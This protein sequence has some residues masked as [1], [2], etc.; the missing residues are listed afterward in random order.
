VAAF[1]QPRQAWE[2]LGSN[3]ALSA[4]KIPDRVLDELTANLLQELE[5]RGLTSLRGPASVAACREIVLSEEPV[6][7][8]NARQYWAEVGRCVSVDLILVPQLTHW[9]QRE[10]GPWGVQSPAS[11]ALRLIWLDPREGRVLRFF[12]FKEEQKALSENLLKIGQFFRRGGQWVS[13]QELALEGIRRG[14][15][16]MGL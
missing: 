11:V 10:G 8:G 1:H 5:K 6:S 9:G 2:L 4:V 12:E 15:E 13:A 14:L 3:E 16:D 7:P